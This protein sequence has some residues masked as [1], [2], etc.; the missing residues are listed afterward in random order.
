MPDPS[1]EK[2]KLNLREMGV[3][4]A[5]IHLWTYYK[6]WVIVP[7]LVILAA[8]SLIRSYIEGSK[9]AY[10]NIAMVNCDSQNVEDLFTPYSEKVGK[11]IVLEPTYFAPTNE[12][13]INVSQEMIASNQKLTAKITGGVTDIVI[14]NARMIQEY[15]ENGLKDLRIVLDETQIKELEERG[16]L[17]Y[18]DFESEAHVPVAINVTGMEFFEP[19]YH[20]S[21][22]K[23]YLFLSA[24]TDKKEEEKLILEYLFFS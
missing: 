14:T 22:E 16:V 12:D 4:G 6:W 21:E 10:L 3:K 18:L 24:F 19:A 9:K 13:S 5:A 17:Y 11:E 23:H 1:L 7:V 15:G 2:K 8:T 20:D